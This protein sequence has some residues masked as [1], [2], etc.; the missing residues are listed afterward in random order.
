MKMAVRKKI[1][2]TGGAGYIGSHTVVA[3]Y[4]NGYEPIILDDLRNSQ[5][6]ILD[7]INKITQSKIQFY[8]GA[9]QDEQ[10]LETIFSAHKIEGII[11][12]AADK[13]VGESVEKPL[14]Y[15]G[16]NLSALISVLNAVQKY[17]VR[18]FVFS[19]SCS[20]YGN[21]P[22]LGQGISEEVNDFYPES[23]YAR[24]KLMGE[25]IIKDWHYSQKET[26]VCLLRYFNP[27]GAHP[28]A[29][30]GELP[31]GIPNNLLPFVTQTA[32]GIRKELRIFGNDYPTSD[33]T[34]IRDYI[35]VDDLAEA[36]VK[37]LNW[38]STQNDVLET[39][40][41]G[42]G[43]GSSVLEIVKKFEELTKVSLNWSFAAR[44]E[45]DVAVVFANNKKIISTLGWQPKYTVDDA[46][47]HAWEWQKTLQ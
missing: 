42:T 17:N 46:I 45:G 20:V 28:S 8:E 18:D 25:Q 10:L 11:H 1:L 16:N 13:A 33:G 6:F 9:C 14:K 22:K 5:R 29:L 35:H 39:F 4:N 41:V 44:R 12:F 36:H 37:A 26:S 21:H 43:K 23:P 19:S 2:V 27:I 31:I 40:N 34:C 32:A 30:I 15:Y 7:R 47:V 3:L 38:L 24:T